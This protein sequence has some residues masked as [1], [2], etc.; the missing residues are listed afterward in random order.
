MREV[1]GVANSSSFPD[2]AA[3]ARPVDSPEAEASVSGKSE[4]RSGSVVAGAGALIAVAAYDTA[5][6]LEAHILLESFGANHN[7][8][9]CYGKRVADGFGWS[10]NWNVGGKA[11]A[12]ET[13]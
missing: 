11:P 1:E 12:E 10:V 3:V 5:C 9:Y 2:S 6:S 7:L 4:A 8:R 13:P